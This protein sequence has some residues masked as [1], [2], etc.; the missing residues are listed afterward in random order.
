M[1][2]DKMMFQLQIITNWR[3]EAPFWVKD[4]TNNP[5]LLSLV[6]VNQAN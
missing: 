4:F 2:A 3:K 5:F 6:E 1:I